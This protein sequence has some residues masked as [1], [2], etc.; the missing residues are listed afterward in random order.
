MVALFDGTWDL[1]DQQIDSITLP[2]EIKNIQFH[3][4]NLSRNKFVSVPTD[5]MKIP[6]LKTID[7]S[8]NIIK[9][10]EPKVIYDANSKTHFCEG[11]HIA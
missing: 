10:I 7:L 5:L 8:H 11:N 3:S 4:I 2:D 9:V 1:S 6:L